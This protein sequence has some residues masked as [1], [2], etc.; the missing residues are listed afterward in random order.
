MGFLGSSALVLVTM[1]LTAPVLDRIE[2]RKNPVLPLDRSRAI[3]ILG[4]MQSYTLVI[5][6]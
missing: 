1:N 4:Y 6:T 2:N 5:Q 3:I